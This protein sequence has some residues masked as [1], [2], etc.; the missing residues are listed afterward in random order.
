M[1]LKRRQRIQS[2]QISHPHRDNERQNLPEQ[3]QDA[4]DAD[5]AKR[6]SKAE[7]EVMK[8][9]KE[10][11]DKLVQEKARIAAE[12]QALSLEG[13]KLK[14]DQMKFDRLS[15]PN[16]PT[17]NDVPPIRQY[18]Q[19]TPLSLNSTPPA[20]MSIRPYANGKVKDGYV[21]KKKRTSFIGDEN[22]KP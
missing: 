2:G 17:V 16:D 11:M 8:K 5:V 20:K 6:K 10:E 12:T 19:L 7:E 18:D 22:E 3:G 21:Q 15:R 1:Y 13:A 14:E 4:A 9:I